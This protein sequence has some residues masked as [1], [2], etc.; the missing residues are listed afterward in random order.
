MVGEVDDAT[1]TRLEALPDF[2]E[3]IRKRGIVGSFLDGGARRS[4]IPEFTEIGFE[5]CHLKRSSRN[6]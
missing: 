4:D 1:N 6:Q 3:E 5:R 2:V